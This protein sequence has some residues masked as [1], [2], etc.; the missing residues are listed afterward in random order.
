MK[1]LYCFALLVA[2]L[3][4]T[5]ANATYD[6][7]LFK[8]EIST[9]L[10]IL[11][12]INSEPDAPGELGREVYETSGAVDNSD[13]RMFIPTTHYMRMGGGLNMGFATTKARYNDQ[14]FESK[15]SYTTQIGLGWNLSSYVRTEIDFQTSEFKFNTLDNT[16]ATY[17]TLGAMLYFDFA[18]R[19]VQ[20]GDITKRRTFVP[21]MGIG[22]GFGTFDYQGTNGHDGMLIAAPRATLGINLMLGD[23][24]GIDV[25]YQYQMVIGNGMG[26]GVE[27][28]K[29]NNQSNVIASI[30]MNF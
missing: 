2:A 13:I 19:Y 1:K 30:R 15:G 8:D 20:I 25:M 23:L 24:I 11:V 16:Q 9:G 12:A 5:N 4:N 3:I 6:N 14:K 28:T 10:D 22:T 17:Q 29:I 27:G 26:W 18:R 7:E 21:Y